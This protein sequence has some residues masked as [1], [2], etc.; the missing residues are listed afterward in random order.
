[1]R[2]GQHHRAFQSGDEEPNLRLQWRRS[3]SGSAFVPAEGN[4]WVETG[5]HVM[6]VNAAGMMPG[7]PEDAKPDTSMPYVMWGGT[8]YAHLM[9][10]VK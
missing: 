2:P 8:P 10:P 9:I 7:Y 6:V 4:N 1:M 5:P 3:F